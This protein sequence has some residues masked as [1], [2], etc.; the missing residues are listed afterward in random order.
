MI[1]YFIKQRE[2]GGGESRERERDGEREGHGGER[3]RGGGGGEEGGERADSHLKGTKQLLVYCHHAPSI[4]VV[5]AVV[6]GREQRDQLPLGKELIPI[7][8][9]LR[10]TGGREKER[11]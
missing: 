1:F 5:T 2:G 8:Y 6:G 11:D 3:G 7:F 9:H 10:V 4:I